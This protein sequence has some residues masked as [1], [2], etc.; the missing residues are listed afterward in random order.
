MNTQYQKI[1]IIGMIIIMLST[2]HSHRQASALV[3]LKQDPPR[4]ISSDLIQIDEYE[5]G[6]TIPGLRQGAVPQGLAYSKTHDLIFIS[7]YFEDK[8]QPSAIAV[9]ERASGQAV[10]TLTLK[11][12]DSVFH[13]GHVGGLAVDEHFLW[14]ASREKVY[15]Y[16]VQ[17]FLSGPQQQAIVPLRAFIPEAWASFSTYDNGILWVGEFVYQGSS[18]RSDASH[19]T[20]DRAGQPQYAWI[21]GYE[22]ATLGSETPKPRYLF[23]IRQKVQGIQLSEKYVFLSISY[24][25]RNDS[26]IAIYHKP[27]AEPPHTYSS[28]DDGSRI[29]LWYLDETNLIAEILLP[30][31][32]EGI[33]M[34][35]GKL[36]VLFE[37]GAQKFQHGGKAPVDQLLFLNPSSLHLTRKR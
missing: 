4:N 8:Q 7:Y 14:V 19:H 3:F 30:P 34:V 9:I 35:D 29:P 32:S 28:W 2:L 12:S 10:R 11:E 20:K 27:L 22:T 24:G 6:P 21:C 23:S 13:Y 26:L 5:L 1:Y 16:D 37:S 25:R 15:Q 18:Y 36:A 31:L 33:T 17:A